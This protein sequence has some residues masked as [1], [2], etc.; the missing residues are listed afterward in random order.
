[1]GGRR[2][3]LS[4]RKRRTLCAYAFVSAAEGGDRADFS[5]PANSGTRDCEGGYVGDERG[6]RRVPAEGVGKVA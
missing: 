5:G 6:R 2:M 1:M 4:G 3:W